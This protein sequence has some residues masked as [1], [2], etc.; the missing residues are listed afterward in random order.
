MRAKIPSTL[1]LKLCQHQQSNRNAGRSIY[2]EKVWKT[3]YANLID[4]FR[5]VFQSASCQIVRDGYL[6]FG[7]DHAYLFFVIA[8]ASKK[9]AGNFI[10]KTVA[11]LSNIPLK[12]WMQEK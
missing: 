9:I 12:N 6:F 5:I 10:M 11:K 7:G 8:L 2:F 1:T 4:R 3:F